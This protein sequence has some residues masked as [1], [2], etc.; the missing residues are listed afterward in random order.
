MGSA[1]IQGQLW[2]ARAQD[3]ATYGEQVCLPLF[4]AALDAA[5]VTVGTRLLD[6]GC[7]AGLLA[8][9]ASFRGA[10]VTALDA[11]PGQVAIARQRLPGADV[12]EGGLEALPFADASF[13][14]VTAVNSVFYA[15]DMAAAMRELVRV[16]RCGGR[17]IVTAWGPPEKCEFLTAV[18]PAL[19]PLLPPPPP[20]TS[21]SHPGALSEP[22]ALAGLLAAQQACAWWTRARSPVP[23]SSRAPRHRGGEIPALGSTKQPLLIAERTR[24]TLYTPMPTAPTRVRMVVFVTKTSFSGWQAND[25][26]AEP[27]SGRAL[28]SLERETF[29]ISL[30][31]LSCKSFLDEME[32]PMMRDA[33]TAVRD[34]GQGARCSKKRG[35]AESYRPISATMNLYGSFRRR[36]SCIRSLVV[37]GVA[38][39]TVSWLTGCGGG[40]VNTQPPVDSQPQLAFPPADY[41]DFSP[42]EAIG[43]VP[44]SRTRLLVTVKEGASEQELEEAIKQVN[45]RVLGKLPELG[46]FLVGIPDS[47]TAQGAYDAAQALRQHPAI[48]NVSL[49][50]FVYIN[51]GTESRGRLIP[52]PSD[53]GGS[54]V[55]H[56]PPAD[57]NWGLEYIRAPQ[58]W[59]WAD[60]L[61]R[62]R[63]PF[64]AVGVMDAG[65]AQNHPDLNFAVI[66]QQVHDHG[67]H[68][69]GIIGAFFN[70]TGA[71]NLNPGQNTGTA[72][73]VDGV[74]AL[75]AVLTGYSVQNPLND[76]DPVLGRVRASHSSFCDSLRDFLT[77]YSIEV[78]NI[79]MGYR[80]CLAQDPTTLA[81]AQRNALERELDRHAAD[82]ARII[83][84]RNLVL[85]VSAGN[86][87]R[88]F[89]GFDGRRWNSPFTRLAHAQNTGGTTVPPDLASEGEKVFVVEATDDAG[90]IAAF[91]NIGGHLSA[92]GVDIYST[93]AG[94]YNSRSGTS[95]AAPH[96]AGAVAYLLR[97]ARATG[98]QPAPRNIANLLAD[99]RTT[100]SSTLPQGQGAPII[101]LFSTAALMAQQNISIHRG[102]VN[103]DDGTPDGNSR[104]NNPLPE[105]FPRGDNKETVNMRDFRVFRDALLQVERDR[106]MIPAGQVDIQNRDLNRDGRINTTEHIY[107]RY[108][109]N[110]DG[111]LDRTG[112]PATQNYGAANTTWRD[113]M[114]PTAPWRDKTDLDILADTSVWGVDEEQVEARRVQ[115]EQA[116][117]IDD[118]KDRWNTTWLLADRNNDSVVDYL[119][120]FDIQVEVLDDA[121]WFSVAEHTG[122]VFFDKFRKGPVPMVV[123]T[124]PIFDITAPKFV[125]YLR[126]IGPADRWEKKDVLLRPVPRYGEDLR[127]RIDWSGMQFS[128]ITRGADPALFPRGSQTMLWERGPRGAK[129]E[130]GYGFFY[131]TGETV[132]EVQQKL[133]EWAEQNL[134]PQTHL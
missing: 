89:A 74:A 7:G 104:V 113:R 3:W 15:A 71:M 119:R 40:G 34:V 75:G 45:G 109:F 121:Q 68:V 26:S 90:N 33:Q 58:A 124:I 6:A 37:I 8:L 132:A 24:F 66:R 99:S 127:I 53:Q 107:A 98:E 38:I 27:Y 120:S 81:P 92:P 43:G 85:I 39:A 20:G 88:A 134:L 76:P 5:G 14:A 129:P 116:Q 30:R 87:R 103:V 70:N 96:V 78:L 49:D 115:D 122:G 51:P 133:R 28:R 16:T 80:W 97:L 82:V 101:D 56:V 126:Q 54:W 29:M 102:L 106:G 69:A 114:S 2:G 17:V 10:Q 67:T 50:F 31:R 13:D 64:T 59:N 118:A 62:K 11:S 65:F 9:L 46:M 105:R 1:A 52:A 35:S 131:T 123:L 86:D 57:G 22:G 112:T 91:S 23:S 48:A 125:R 128:S 44:V 63:P 110:G 83:R 84:G 41:N 4:G 93:V 55:W 79:S 25:R 100:R 60:F 42:L 32:V 36:G 47:E 111:I 18:M 19:G 21:P 130:E 12:R 94:G 72:V 95:M 61:A 108:D 77:R 73:G 117:T